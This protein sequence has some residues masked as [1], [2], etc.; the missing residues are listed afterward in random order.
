MESKQPT[1]I[2]EIMP[3]AGL[4]YSEKA[5]LSEILCKPKIMPLKSVTLVKL[6]QMESNLATMAGKAPGT[7]F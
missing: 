6:E 4:V 5:T 3:K 7:A 2:K 1:A